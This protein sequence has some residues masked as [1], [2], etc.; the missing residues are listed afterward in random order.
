MQAPPLWHRHIGSE[1][2]SNGGITRP[3]DSRL[4]AT[5]YAAAGALRSQLERAADG[6][7]VEASLASSNLPPTAAGN[8]TSVDGEAM[9]NGGGSRRWASTVASIV[10]WCVCGHAAHANWPRAGTL[11]VCVREYRQRGLCI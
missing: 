11:P 2:L 10:G 6:K 1:A 9:Q 4:S 8:Q 5:Q 7:T 3:P